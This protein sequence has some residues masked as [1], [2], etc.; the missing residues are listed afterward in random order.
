[1]RFLYVTIIILFMASHFCCY[2]NATGNTAPPNEKSTSESSGQKGA[3]Q[4]DS[5]ASYVKGQILLK[6][7][8]GGSPDEL[9]SI[10]PGAEVKV[11]DHFPEIGAYCLEIKGAGTVPQ[12]IEKLK[13]SPLI[14][15]VEPNYIQ[16]PAEERLNDSQLPDTGKLDD[17]DQ[18]VP[19][20]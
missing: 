11:V 10:L 12:I 18:K 13:D 3:E 20:E 19:K 7:K 5:P 4:K 2:N 15:Y 17:S 16:F 6:F 9:T 14:E 1:M 8:E